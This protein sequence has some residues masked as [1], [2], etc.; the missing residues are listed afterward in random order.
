MGKYGTSENVQHGG[1]HSTPPPLFRII[2]MH[3]P[4]TRHIGTSLQENG[5]KRAVS[6]PPHP[7]RDTGTSLQENGGL[8][9]ICLHV[10]MLFA[11]LSLAAVGKVSKPRRGHPLVESSCLRLTLW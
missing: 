5:D 2:K 8:G 10:C 6:P 3:P 11:L 1:K 4:P 9:K 7:H